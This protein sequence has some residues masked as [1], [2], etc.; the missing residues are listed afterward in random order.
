MDTLSLRDVTAEDAK[1]VFEWRNDP[2]IIAKGSLNKTVTWEEHSNW[3]SGLLGDPASHMFIIEID[4]APAGQVRFM[5]ESG[6]HNADISIYLLKDYIGQGYGV[7]AL[8]QACSHIFNVLDI[9]GV[10]AYI[11]EENEQSLNAF[12]KAGFQAIDHSGMKEKNIEPKPDHQTYYFADAGS[13]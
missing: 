12:E 9:S 6:T 2:W 13:A 4:G 5:G 7:Q 11:L 10:V 8:R 1:L 3:F